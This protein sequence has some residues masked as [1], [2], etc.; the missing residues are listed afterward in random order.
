VGIQPRGV[1]IPGTVPAPLPSAPFE[2]FTL[3]PGERRVVVASG[4]PTC[5]GSFHTGALT[6]RARTALGLT[7]EVVVRPAEPDA[8]SC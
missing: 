7:R 8:G 1:T 5:E 4:R 2:P 3:D 6:V